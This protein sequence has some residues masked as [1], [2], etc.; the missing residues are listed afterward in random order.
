M[1]R[2]TFAA[3][4]FGSIAAGCGDNKKTVE[5]AYPT[6]QECFDDHH[7]VEAFNVIDSI[8]ICCIDHPIAGSDA[9]IV[10]GATAAACTTFVND[11]LDAASATDP[12]VS[13]ACDE[14]LVERDA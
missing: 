8:K 11:E 14:Y 9:N 7:T 2:L 12:D 3:A 5:Q 13:T 10:C 6:F 4:L 1:L